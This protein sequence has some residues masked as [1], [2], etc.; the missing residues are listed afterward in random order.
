M[1]IFVE[2]FPFSILLKSFPTLTAGVG[3]D[4]VWRGKRKNL[5]PFDTDIGILLVI[6]FFG[7]C[8][9]I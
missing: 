9:V 4:I 3:M 2:L 7:M 6:L 1:L 8:V 5:D